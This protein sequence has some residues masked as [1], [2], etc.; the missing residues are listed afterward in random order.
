MQISTIG[1]N[2][3][4]I[5]EG[6]Q[7]IG[8][9]VKAVPSFEEQIKLAGMVEDLRRALDRPQPDT[10]TV[11]ELFAGLKKASLTIAKATWTAYKDPLKAVGIVWEALTDDPANT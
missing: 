9:A 3:G 1:G 5:V 7:T 6:T 2:V 4:N 11:R 8:D 10:L